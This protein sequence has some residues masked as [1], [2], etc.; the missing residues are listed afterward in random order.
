MKITLE[1]GEWGYFI[2]PQSFLTEEI[3]SATD[4]PPNAV[5]IKKT[6]QHIEDLGRTVVT[7]AYYLVQSDKAHKEN[8]NTVKK[9]LAEQ[10]LKYLNAHTAW[11]PYTSLKKRIQRSYRLNYQPN[12][13]D[14]FELT[15]NEEMLG[16][17]SIAVYFDNLGPSTVLSPEELEEQSWT[18]EGSQGNRYTVRKK[19]IDWECSCPQW[20]YR[21]RSTGTDC[22]H[23]K[24]IKAKG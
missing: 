2:H 1:K 22:K 23:I 11:A 19:G 3:A 24:S 13:Y 21:G 15:I 18:V 10:M 8:K 9:H 5:I 12:K 6:R 17:T 7:T 4:I 20:V 14:S 16:G